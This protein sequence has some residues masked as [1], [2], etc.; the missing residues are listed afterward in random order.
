MTKPHLDTRVAGF[1]LIVMLAVI[2][3][4]G[5]GLT[6]RSASASSGRTSETSAFSVDAWQPADRG[7]IDPDVFAMA[8]HAAE[9]AVSRGDA[10]DPGTLTVIDFSKPSTERRMWVY[11]LRARTLLFEELVSH[12]RGSGVAMATSFSNRPESTQSSLGLY[13]TAETYFGKHGFS[14]RLDGLEPGINDRARERAIV[15]H[16]AEY[17][18]GATAKALASSAGASD[19]PPCVPKSHGHSSKR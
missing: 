19:A 5:L 12:G 14:L 16:G 4:S 8:L 11:D 10:V 13:R 17:V 7:A 3:V 18:N 1:R 6:D 15:M 9:T 2:A